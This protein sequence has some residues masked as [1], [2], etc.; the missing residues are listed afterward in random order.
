MRY[1]ILLLCVSLLTLCALASAEKPNV[2]SPYGVCAHLG[3]GMEFD[4][5]PKNLAAMRAAG[6]RWARADFSWNG[7]EWKKGDWHFNHLDRVLDEADKAG[8]TILP[9]LDYS[10]SW[11]RGMLSTRKEQLLPGGEV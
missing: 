2:E 5:M 7:V 3:G 6:I 11:R 1:R 4:A 8:I 10:I 9:I